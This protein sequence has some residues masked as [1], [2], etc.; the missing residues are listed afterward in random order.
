MANLANATWTDQSVVA[1]T[2]GTL[3][4][5]SDC[6]AYIASKMRR[7]TF[8]ATTSP[9]QTEIQ[10]EIIRGKQELTEV[11]GF[12][13]QRKY[14]YCDATA[15]SYRYNLPPDYGGHPVLRD[16]TNDFRPEYIDPHKFDLKWPDMSEETNGDTEAFTVK[17]RELWIY[18]PADAAIRFELEYQRTGDDSTANDL[19]YI[20]ESL[21][22]KI[23]DFGIYQGFKILHMWQEASAYKQDWMEGLL[24]AKRSDGKKKWAAT[25]FQALSWQ[26]AYTARYAQK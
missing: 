22:F 11:F 12:T 16:M 20:P 3:N 18:P 7:G 25:G 5:I 14:S 10:E 26:Q 2:A 15:S 13:W 8:S 9:T 21:R 24:K 19:S 4:T 17:D 23:C 1:F 6:E